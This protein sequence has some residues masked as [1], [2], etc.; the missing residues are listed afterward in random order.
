MTNLSITFE[1]SMSPTMTIRK[2]TQN[3]EIGGDLGQLEVIH[4]YRQPNHSIERI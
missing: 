1:V 2:A 4:G 3:V